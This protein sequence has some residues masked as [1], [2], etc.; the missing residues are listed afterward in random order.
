VLR[1]IQSLQFSAQLPRTYRQTVNQRRSPLI[2]HPHSLVHKPDAP[3]T[4][5]F[6]LVLEELEVLRGSFSSDAA[7]SARIVRAH[8]L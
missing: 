5:T 2:C 3:S 4:G 1:P 6:D 8:R 7:R